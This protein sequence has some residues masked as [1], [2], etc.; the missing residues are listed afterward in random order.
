MGIE[1]IHRLVKRS[2]QAPESVIELLN[3]TLIGT[4]GSLYQ[5][6]DTSTKIHLL[7][8]PHFIYF[9]R[10]NRCI[11]NLTI[12]ERTVQ[13]N[14]NEF[15]S[16]YLRYFA[17]DKIFQGGSKSSKGHSSFHHYF[18]QLFKSSNFNPLA[19]KTEKSIY[20]AFIDPENLRSF[21]MNEKL[22][23][24]TV[25]AFT[26]TAF[27]RVKPS[28]SSRLERIQESDIPAARELIRNF[29]RDFN[30]YSEIHLFESSHFFVLKNKGEIIAGI[31][32]N[33]VRF[34]IKSLA[35]WGGKLLVKALPYLPRIKRLIQPKEQ[36]FL[37]TEGLFWKEGYEQQVEEL[38]N[39]VLAETEHH[40]LLIWTDDQNKMLEKLP[41]KWGLIQR[42][43]K[44]NPIH[45]VA[46]FNGFQPQEI[47]QII[48]KKKYLSGFDMS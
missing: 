10:N 11:A 28:P 14:G 21:A 23:F 9:E 6:L 38:L 41:V 7:H 12:C 42:V 24:Q 17:F 36:R 22:G 2:R 13:L 45:I 30:F 25:G 44:D 35:G 1:H 5:L 4:N 43:K 29:Y 31:Q 32:A 27:S 18:Q 33:P 16:L 15:H 19:P 46:K 26:T 48:H 40:L 8:Q 47:D 39:G 34:H 3:N 20:W 37:A